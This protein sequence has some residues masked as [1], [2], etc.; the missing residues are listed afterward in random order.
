MLEERGVE[1]RYREY[2]KEPLGAD[3]IRHV[4]DLLG[5]GP[6]AVLRRNDRAF[7]EQGLDGTEDDDRLI[8]LMSEY[9][10]LLQ[11]PIGILGDRAIVG[12]P[13]ERVLELL[14]RG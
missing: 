2:R 7:R 10:T 13:P 11:R 9:P 1:F 5:V 4:L 6:K 8:T 14:D 12:R 3:E